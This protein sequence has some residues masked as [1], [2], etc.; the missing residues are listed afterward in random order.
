MSF[1]NWKRLLQEVAEMRQQGNGSGTDQK[2]KAH[3]II[4]NNPKGRTQCDP[5]KGT[6][7]EDAF[8]RTRTEKSNL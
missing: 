8:K 6:G 4:R 1:E 2:G 5:R 7:K 3:D